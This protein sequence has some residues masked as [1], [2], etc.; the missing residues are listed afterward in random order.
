MS[1]NDIN[2]TKAKKKLNTYARYSG[3]GFQMAVTIGLGIWLGMYLDEKMENTKP[4]MTALCALVFMILSLYSV[5]NKTK[6]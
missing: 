4:Y 1:D 2:T 3:I 5:V 6:I